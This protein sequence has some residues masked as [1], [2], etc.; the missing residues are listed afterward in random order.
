MSRD[1]YTRETPWSV[2]A[3]AR[4][5]TAY[6]QDGS[7]VA[8]GVGRYAFIDPVVIPGTVNLIPLARQDFSG[9]TAL[10]GATVTVSQN[11]MV[12]EWGTVKATRLQSTGGSS[13]VKYSLANIVNP[14]VAGQPYTG[15]L[16]VKN[17]GAKAVVI[18]LSLPG[19]TTVT[20]NPGE[21]KPVAVSGTG[22]GVTGLNLRFGTAA[23]G[24][25]FDILAYQP[26]AENRS[27]ATPFT[28]NSRNVALAAGPNGR[29]L[30]I[31][32]AVTNLIALARQDFSGW[33]EL[34]GAVA[35][36][37]QNQ[38][39]PEWG[40]SAATR[41]Q[42]A[43]GSSTAKYSLANIVNPSVT[44]Q[45]YTGLLKIKN[46]GAKAVVIGFSLAGAISVTVNPGETKDVK[47]TTTGD[48]AT[49][50][51][52]RFSTTAAGDAI[53]VLAW[54]PLAAATARTTSWHESTRVAETL[55]LPASVLPATG[56]AGSWEH[57]LVPGATAYLQTSPKPRLFSLEGS[58]GYITVRH[59]SDSASFELVFTDG[60]A[61]TTATFADTLIPSA[62][63]RLSLTWNATV[64][65]LFVDGT[66]VATI[67]TPALPAA[68]TGAEIG[69]SVA[70]TYA[71][72]LHQTVRI[73]S[74]VRAISE[75]KA[76]IGKPL[77]MDNAT[78]GLWLVPNNGEALL[79][80]YTDQSAQL[81]GA[82]QRPHKVVD[83]LPQQRGRDS[84]GNPYIYHHGGVRRVRQEPQ[85]IR[86]TE[87]DLVNLTTFVQTG[88][89]GVRR[90]CTWVDFD[91]TARTVR[92][93][94][95]KL[96]PV[97][98]NGFYAVVLPSE[99]EI[100]L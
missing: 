64:A 81:P 17:I 59:A 73:S 27:T 67:N 71:D 63:V 68:F 5:S 15:S 66:E 46:I 2:A 26:Q 23:A 53:D 36:I 22:D 24:D 93:L 74:R 6:G 91:G 20:I 11:Q 7:Q 12:P 79:V 42:T 25:D 72:S 80:R 1:L 95:G 19:A 35:T 54:R 94:T 75:V 48:G 13:T 61:T 77:R 84:L 97:P 57:D 62:K 49:G 85:Y 87:T 39:V 29:G 56:A 32:G 69:Y 40:T 78:K 3:F 92:L 100:A 38:A 51:N 9:W 50:L 65:R 21:V 31:E 88:L 10:S 44:G 86:L 98:D 16:L 96:D 70:T 76:S 18:S 58:S 82:P 55:T 45:P 89:G 34:S 52:L 60:T 83:S 30:L 47:I 90:N 28:P 41:V 43:G 33:T 8:N 99:E 14:S 37:T 4:A